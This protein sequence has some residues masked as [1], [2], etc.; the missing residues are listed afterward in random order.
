MAGRQ[1][2]NVTKTADRMEREHI[3]VEA[4]RGDWTLSEKADRYGRA[5]TISGDPE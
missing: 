4:G 1:G 2:G 5:V 3:G